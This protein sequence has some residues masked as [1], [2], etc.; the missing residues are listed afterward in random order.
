LLR[1]LGRNRMAEEVE[2]GRSSSLD[3]VQAVV[4]GRMAE[5]DRQA[6]AVMVPRMKLG[7]QDPE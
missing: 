1:S 6:A 4:A 5:Q 7:R 2:A 3:I